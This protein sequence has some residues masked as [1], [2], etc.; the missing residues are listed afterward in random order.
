MPE[1]PPISSPGAASTR[2]R[3]GVHIVPTKEQQIAA[4]AFLRGRPVD[5]AMQEPIE[6]AVAGFGWAER[7]YIAEARAQ[8]DRSRIWNTTRWII[9][10]ALAQQVVR[11]G[12]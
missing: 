3:S 12:G 8:G 9:A 7:Q 4:A 2:T 5:S 11:A 1:N 10:N 6:R